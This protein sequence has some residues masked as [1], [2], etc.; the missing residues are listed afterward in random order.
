MAD[1][2]LIVLH[3][4]DKV[5]VALTDLHQGEKLVV[6]DM[7]IVLQSDIHFCH[8]FSLTS[9]S[10]NEKILKYGLPIGVCTKN[11]RAGEWVHMHNLK[12]NYKPVDIEK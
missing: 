5:G 8:K 4:D 12:S 1:K 3:S 2:R 10:E 6:K 9:I 11:I 7:I